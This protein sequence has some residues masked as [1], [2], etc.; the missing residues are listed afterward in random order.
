CFNSS[1]L[2]YGGDVAVGAMTILTS[3]MQFAMLP[4][5]GLSQGAQPITSYNYGAGNAE[6]VKRTFRLL[7]TVS[8]VYSCTLWLLIQLF[9]QAFASI[10]TPDPALLSFSARALRIYCGVLGLFGVQIACQ[11]T[12]V[13]IGYASSSIIVA[14]MR[15]FV[16]LLPL[17]YLMPMLM[18]DKTMAVYTAEP[19]ADFLA[20]TFTAILFRSQFK[21]AIASMAAKMPS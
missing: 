20:V 5:Q 18:Q 15:K 19:V 21:K 4:L 1:L 13:A 10:F 9:P 6:R 7:L 12:F 16:L 2:R 8:L 17:I 11:M 3:V 14:V